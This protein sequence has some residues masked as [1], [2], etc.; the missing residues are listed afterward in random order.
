MAGHWRCAVHGAGD[1]QYGG[2]RVLI[3]GCPFCWIVQLEAMFA[4]HVAREAAIVRAAEE[5]AHACGSSNK[6]LGGYEPVV[7]ATL[8]LCA[9]VRG[10]GEG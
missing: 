6:A 1:Q 9:A 3:E 4:T 8:R 7:S 5:L 2:G 10:G